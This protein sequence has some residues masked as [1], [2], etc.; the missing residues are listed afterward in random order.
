M[1]EVNQQI[2]QI[3]IS[4]E[5]AEKYVQT[6]RD[7]DELYKNPLFKK[8]IL[9]IYFKTEP[10]RL[11]MLKSDISMQ[12]E[13]D[14]I[15]LDHSIRGIGARQ[16][17]GRAG[18][19]GARMSE[20][21]MIAERETLGAAAGRNARIDPQGIK[22]VVHCPVVFAAPE[23]MVHVG[24]FMCRKIIRVEPGHHEPECLVGIVFDLEPD[25]LDAALF[26][27]DIKRLPSF[28][29]AQYRNADAYTIA[30]LG[31]DAFL[32]RDLINRRRFKGRAAACDGRCNADRHQ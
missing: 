15:S 14:Q 25:G 9:D 11:V 5:H 23:V 19:Q 22:V 31:M 32:E 24:G 7:L 28:V 8:I 1:N 18:Q 4:L 12:S 10:V 26:Q 30:F 17:V 13:E 29:P 27:L 20:R 2:Q 16:A 21:S 6:A 3:E